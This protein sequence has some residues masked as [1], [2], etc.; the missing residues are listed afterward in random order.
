MRALI[1]DPA[2][3]AGIRLGKAAE[4]V[5]GNRQALVEVSA[6]SFNFGELAYLAKQVKPGV[7]P[8]WDAAGVVIQ[9]ASDGSGPAAGTRVVTFGWSGGWAQ[10]RAV[11]TTELAIL[12]DSVEFGAASTLPVAGITALRALRQLGSVIGQRILIT[13]AS[14]GVG[15]FAVQLAAHAGA[16]VVAAVG[17]PARGEGLRELGAGEIVTNLA[18]V[19]EPVAG[20][21]D[22]VGGQHLAQAFS[23]LQKGGTAQAIGQAS[24]QPTTIDF[25]QERVEGGGDRRI[26]PFVI[27]TSGFGEDLGYLVELLAA[28]RLKADIG[29]R[30]SWTQAPEAAEALL[31]RR[32]AGK[33]VL[34]TTDN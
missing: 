29:W 30:T 14:G 20:V 12:P 1:H 21:L 33:A 27:G 6:V 16:H 28:G 17:S 13:G 18:D 31:A 25:E 4:P 23:L 2:A 10:L 34:D 32:V 22:N 8:G 26:E 15:R 5:P 7:I 19:A 24:M 11:D 9:P 3:P